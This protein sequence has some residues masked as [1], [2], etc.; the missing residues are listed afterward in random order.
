MADLLVRDIEPALRREIKE[1]A[2]RHGRSLSAEVK[3]LIRSGLAVSPAS[4][5]K[6]GD[7]LFSLVP[8]EARD[9]DLVFEIDDRPQAPDFE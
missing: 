9:D 2:R 8:Q 7:W 4:P 3:A 6:F 1:R 5:D